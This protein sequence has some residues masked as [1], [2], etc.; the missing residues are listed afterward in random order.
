MA[1]KKNNNKKQDFYKTNKQI[2]H[3]E[4]RIVG[5]NLEN[6]GDVVSIQ[7]ALNLADDLDVD[8]VEI[9]PNANPPVCK[10]IDF[11]KFLYDIKRKKKEQEKKQ[12][13]TSQ[14]TKEIKFG[15][16]TDDHDYEFKK[17]H[18][19]SFLK[20]NNIVKAFVFF[21]GREIQFKEQGKLLLLRLANDLSELG[22]P[23]SA[24]PKLEG[25]RMTI[26]IRPKKK[27]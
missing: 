23:D 14:D 6:S 15:P 25:K 20:K 16:N 12:R 17:R 1:K 7:E 27:K 3:S 19:E 4:V 26:Y 9:S 2:R 24:K 10:L 5:D 18:A 22:V 21:K 11:S 8:L 13:E